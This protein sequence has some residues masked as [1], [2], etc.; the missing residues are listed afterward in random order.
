MTETEGWIVIIHTLF[1]FVACIGVSENA[2]RPSTARRSSAF[3]L[4][5]WHVLA[6]A[7]ASVAVAAAVAGAVFENGLLSAMIIVLGVPGM[8][9]LITWMGACGIAD[10]LFRKAI[11][12]TLARRAPGPCLACGGSIKSSENRSDYHIM[13]DAYHDSLGTMSIHHS[14]ECIAAGLRALTKCSTDYGRHHMTAMHHIGP[15]TFTYDFVAGPKRGFRFKTVTDDD[16]MHDA[17]AAFLKAYR[18]DRSV[19]LATLH[20]AGAPV[21]MPILLP[22]TNSSIDQRAL[23]SKKHKKALADAEAKAIHAIAMLGKNP[24]DVVV[25]L[26]DYATATLAKLKAARKPEAG[27]GSGT[28]TILEAT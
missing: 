23:A 20:D 3:S 16:T 17:T 14:S 8:I 27:I 24:F 13:N 12:K 22:A 7:V 10:R 15:K 25:V 18:H 9:G 26:A 5:P 4:L 1:I 28:N 6:M 11:A 19:V 2:V 21:R